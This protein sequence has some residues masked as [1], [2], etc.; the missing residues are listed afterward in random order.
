MGATVS[1]TAAGEDTYLSGDPGDPSRQLIRQ[2]LGAVCDHER[3]MVRLRL[4]TGRQHKADAGGYAYGAPPFGFRSERGELVP[5][6]TGPTDQ[7]ARMRLR[8]GRL[9]AMAQADWSSEIV[10]RRSMS[11]NLERRR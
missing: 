9:R 6:P 1:S 10:T 3:S 4:S 7:P 11:T 5:R 8:R 2:V